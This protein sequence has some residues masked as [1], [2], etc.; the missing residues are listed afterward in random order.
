[1]PAPAA[2]LFPDAR[3]WPPSFLLSSAFA[4]LGSPQKGA[5]AVQGLNGKPCHR[6]KP[7][8]VR[9]KFPPED[10][11]R[12]QEAPGA[13][14]RSRGL[15]V[16][17]ARSLELVGCLRFSHPSAVWARGE[18]AGARVEQGKLGGPSRSGA[19]SGTEDLGSVP[20]GKPVFSARTRSAVGQLV[21]G[22]GNQ[23]FYCFTL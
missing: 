22:Y 7:M 10:S 19:R 21:A 13:A 8:G 14:G 5:L 16:L 23:G 18:K 1:M 11:W 6:W 20:K 3:G 15:S 17:W 2:L 9:T 12:G 4:H